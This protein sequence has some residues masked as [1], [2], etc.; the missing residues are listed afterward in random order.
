M[1][2]NMYLLIS[3]DFGEI[4]RSGILHVVKWK[5]ANNYFWNEKGEKIGKNLREG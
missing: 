4:F 1:E 2:K 5:F 3:L